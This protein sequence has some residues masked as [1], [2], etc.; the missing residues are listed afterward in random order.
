[1]IPNSKRLCFAAPLISLSG[2]YSCD[3]PVLMMVM[4]IKR[5]RYGYFIYNTHIY[6]VI[7]GPLLSVFQSQ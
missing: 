5:I 3:I 2:S 6:D 4:L 7:I 1:M